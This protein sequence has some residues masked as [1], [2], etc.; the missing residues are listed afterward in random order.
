MSNTAFRR[1]KSY[2]FGVQALC[3]TMKQ[4]ISMLLRDS[5]GSGTCSGSGDLYGGVG[6]QLLNIAVYECISLYM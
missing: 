6:L 2:S 4:T 3:L 1:G 5:H